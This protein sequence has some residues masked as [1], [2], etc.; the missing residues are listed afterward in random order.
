MV[1]SDKTIEKTINKYQKCQDGIRVYSTTE[2][3]VQSWV[4][5]SHII[6]QCDLPFEEGVLANPH[7]LTKIYR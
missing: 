5:T 4:L 3:T 6:T 2:G 1:T 7:S